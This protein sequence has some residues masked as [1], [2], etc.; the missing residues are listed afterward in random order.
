MGATAGKLPEEA[1]L[2]GQQQQQRSQ[3]RSPSTV[4]FCLLTAL[5]LL[6]AIG[7]SGRGDAPWLRLVVRLHTVGASVACAATPQQT[8]ATG[9]A[10]SCILVARQPPPKCLFYN[11]KQLAGPCNFDPARLACT[12]P[13]ATR[14]TVAA[15]PGC[16][17]GAAAAA[18]T[19][20]RAAAASQEQR[21]QQRAQRGRSMLLPP[22]MPRRQPK[23][24]VH[25]STPGSWGPP[26]TAAAAAA[27]GWQP[28]TVFRP[29]NTSSCPGPAVTGAAGLVGWARATGFRRL[30]MCGDSTMRQFYQR[31]VTLA[32]AEQV[33]VDVVSQRYA[34]YALG[35]AA[36]Q[37]DTLQDSLWFSQDGHPPS[38]RSN[39]SASRAAHE[40][41]VARSAPGAALPAGMASQELSVSLVMGTL[42]SYQQQTMA[43]LVR[44]VPLDWHETAIVLS[45]CYWHT[46]AA[47]AQVWPEWWTF[48]QALRAHARWV[49][50]VTCPVPPA[51][52]NGHMLAA[53]NAHLRRLVAWAYF[54]ANEGKRGPVESKVYDGT[55]YKYYDVVRVDRGGTCRDA[56]NFSLWQGLLCLL[57]A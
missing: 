18:E 35:W 14:T 27:G 52:R 6:A 24:H 17:A 32:R 34:H 25:P 44:D 26:T 19:G 43:A 55:Y 30:V 54:T 39:G 10:E 13:E 29:A 1:L 12:F 46:T 7:S 57:A 8:V 2:Q 28:G 21:K 40:G 45:M 5:L 3:V 31:V 20:T 37:P 51:L 15:T 9:A 11:D 50:L 4:A 42:R 33:T 22:V 49:V 56:A 16:A 53:R 48:V 23:L 41:L 36:G 38:L 47:D